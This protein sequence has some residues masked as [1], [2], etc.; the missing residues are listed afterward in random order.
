MMIAAQSRAEMP[1]LV[2]APPAEGSVAVADGISAFERIYAVVTHPRCANCHVGANNIPMWDGGIA[3]PARPHGMNIDAGISRI[4][5]ETLMCSTCHRTSPV[6]ES[7]PHAPPHTALDWR[8]APVEFEW[9]GKSPAEI[10]AQLS[11]PARTGGRD[12]MALAEHLVDD[13]NHRG[14]VLWGW[15]PG[16]G[17]DPAPGSLQQ[18]VDDVLAWGVAGQPCPIR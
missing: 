12:W 4:G 3:G 13:A 10:C 15:M 11:D 9:F 1:V 7:A 2:I 6:L 16:G 8:L 14:F 5:A 18:H 17:R